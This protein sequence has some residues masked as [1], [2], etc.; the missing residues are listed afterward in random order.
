MTRTKPTQEGEL[1]YLGCRRLIL[2][3]QA[4]KD[5]L[6]RRSRSKAQKELIAV[7]T[8]ILAKGKA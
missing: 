8:A 6:A 4:R 3:E 2:L 5:A 7:T 1:H